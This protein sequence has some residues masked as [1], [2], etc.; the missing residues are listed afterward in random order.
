VEAIEVAAG[1]V[2]DAMLS[3]RR[4]D[5]KAQ[6]R[7]IRLDARRLLLGLRVV[8]QVAFGQLG[9]GRSLAQLVA[10]LGRIEATAHVSEPLLRHAARLLGSQLA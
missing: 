4:Q 7:T 6:G 5:M 10:L 1:H 9:H 2:G 8:A 3:E